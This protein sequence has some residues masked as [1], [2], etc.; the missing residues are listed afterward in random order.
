MTDAPEGSDPNT[1]IRCD[2]EGKIFLSEREWI[3]LEGLLRKVVRE[4]VR[5]ELLSLEIDE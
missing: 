3:R 4:E 2:T 5:A 1:I